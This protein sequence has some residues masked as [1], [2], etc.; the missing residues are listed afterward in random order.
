MD[1]VAESGRNPVSKHHIQFDLGVENEQ[2]HAERDCRTRLAR[3]YSQARTGTG[4]TR[5]SLFS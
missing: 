1:A 2:A 5:F 3:S 4:K